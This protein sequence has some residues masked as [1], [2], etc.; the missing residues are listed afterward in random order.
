M[1]VDEAE[2]H[3][4]IRIPGVLAWWWSFHVQ[5]FYLD[6]P[7]TTKPHGWVS[8]HISRVI[9]YLMYGYFRIPCTALKKTVK[10]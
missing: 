5:M 4:S 9:R 7:V 3:G 8:S 6:L 2:V 1:L 10:R